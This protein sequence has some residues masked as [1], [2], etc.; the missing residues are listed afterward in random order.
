MLTNCV[1]VVVKTINQ[2]ICRFKQAICHK[3]KKKGHIAKERHSSQAGIVPQRQP[4]PSETHPVH[5]I[6]QEESSEEL[7]AMYNFPGAQINPIQV[8]VNIGD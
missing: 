5:Q 1:T 8:V 4:H 2:P 6:A 7:N 3:C